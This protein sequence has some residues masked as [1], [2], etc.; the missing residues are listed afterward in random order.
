MRPIPTTRGTHV[1]K[2]GSDADSIFFL[3]RGTVEVLHLGHSVARVMAPATFGEAALLRDEMEAANKRQSG[4][5]T[6]SAS[7]CGARLRAC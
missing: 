4:Y 5:R 6:T 7:M 3:Q 2:Q 1:A